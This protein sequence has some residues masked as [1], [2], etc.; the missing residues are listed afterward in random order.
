MVK[1][2]SVQHSIPAHVTQRHPAFH[3]GTDPGGR[4]GAL[5]IKSGGTEEKSEGKLNGYGV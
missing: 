3:H 4:M 1:K 2:H 5:L